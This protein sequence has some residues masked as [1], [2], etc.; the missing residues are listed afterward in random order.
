LQI[1]FLNPNHTTPNANPLVLQEATA[2]QTVNRCRRH[3]QPVGG[4]LRSQ[5]GHVPVLPLF[6][7]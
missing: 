4:L 5:D 6:T 7:L 2:T 3:P 1:F